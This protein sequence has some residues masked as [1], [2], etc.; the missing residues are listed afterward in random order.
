MAGEREVCAVVLAAGRSTRMGQPKL[1][2]PWGERTIIGQVLA[3]LREGGAG[4]IVIVTGP[5]EAAIARAADEFRQPRPVRLVPNPDYQRTE[6]LVSLQV[7][8]RALQPDCAAALVAIGDGPTVTAAVVR[9]VMDAYKP[10]V[11]K[12]VVPSF[13]M[14]RGHPWLVTRELFPALLALPADKTPRDFLEAHKDD[15]HYVVM[16][17]PEILQ[18]VDTPEDYREM[19]AIKRSPR[20]KPR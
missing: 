18:D 2:L 15:I 12:I 13:Q 5:E 9:A 10:G 1:L 4:D 7:G 3:A 17:A 20:S 16:D 11:T 6:M 19:R 14:R 8:I